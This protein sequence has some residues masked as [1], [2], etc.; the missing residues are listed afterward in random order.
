MYRAF[1]S[2]K[3]DDQLL[4]LMVVVDQPEIANI[5]NTKKYKRFLMHLI[6]QHVSIHSNGSS[7]NNFQHI[8]LTEKLIFEIQLAVLRK[9]FKHSCAPNMIYS[10]DNGA[11]KGIAVHPIIKGEEITVNQFDI[12]IENEL[13]RRQIIF[14]KTG[15]TCNCEKCKYQAIQENSAFQCNIDFKF[16]S[17]KCGILPHMFSSDEADESIMHCESFLEMYGRAQWCNEIE[18]VVKF[19]T[20]MLDYRDMR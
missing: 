10:F 11:T 3:N 18:C 13:E 8:S 19:Y 4:K 16:I 12:G 17:A 15:K 20:M 1:L 6:V 7:S 14:Q 2:L 5:F 9:S